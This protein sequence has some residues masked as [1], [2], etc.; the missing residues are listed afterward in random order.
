MNH[1]DNKEGGC[2]EDSQRALGQVSHADN[3]FFNVHDR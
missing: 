3:D 1:P 2:Y